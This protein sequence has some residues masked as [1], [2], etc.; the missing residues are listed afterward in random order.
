MQLKRKQITAP[1]LNYMVMVKHKGAGNTP[2]SLTFDTCGEI[3]PYLDS[4][5]LEQVGEVV[6]RDVEQ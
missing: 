6:T 4:F 1:G 2:F 3:K 5:Q